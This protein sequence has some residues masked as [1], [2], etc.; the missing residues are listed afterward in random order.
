MDGVCSKMPEF[1]SG[2]STFM[3]DTAKS[4]PRVRYYFHEAEK[5]PVI[6]AKRNWMV[7]NSTGYVITSLIAVAVLTSKSGL[8]CVRGYSEVIVMFDVDDYYGPEYISRMV[9]LLK[10]SSNDTGM[11]KLHAWFSLGEGWLMDPPTRYKAYTYIDMEHDP[12]GWGWTYVFWKKTYNNPDIHYGEVDASEEAGLFHSLRRGGFKIG[13]FADRWFLCL[14]IV[15][16]SIVR[17]TGAGPCR[18]NERGCINLP[19]F[20]VMKGFGGEQRL[21]PWLDLWAAKE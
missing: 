15:T 19:D 11:V 5:P 12:L 18:A 9:W 2:P 14:R 6:G 7:R 21:K 16:Y 20:M 17:T 1:V 8:L 13:T 10:Q 4:D 3:A